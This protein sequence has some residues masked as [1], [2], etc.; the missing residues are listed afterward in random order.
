MS[1]DPRVKVG[2]GAVVLRD[3][4]LLMQQRA[5]DASHGGGCWSVPGGWVDYGEHPAHAALRELREE[6]GMQGWGPSLLGTVANT[7]PDLDLHVVC[8]FYRVRASGA[9]Q[10]T[11]P[12]K[13]IEVR[14][15]RLDEV[16]AMTPHFPP[17]ADLLRA[18]WLP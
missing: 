4:H 12:D 14:W 3:G 16:E 7:Y 9:P 18:G 15:V 2:V 10:N 8:N 17:F 13:T 11:E 5:E 6:T 1:A